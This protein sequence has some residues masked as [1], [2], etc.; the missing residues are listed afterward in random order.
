MTT[1]DPLDPLLDHWSQTPDPSPRLTSEVWR[2]IALAEEASHPARAGFWAGIES[3]FARPP[4]ATMFVASCAL[5]GLFLAEVRVNRL[6]QER[7]AQLAR[8]YLQLIDPLLKADR[9]AQNP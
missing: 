8:S 1:P 2:R 9:I 3:W 5:L 6:Q 4:F 7:S